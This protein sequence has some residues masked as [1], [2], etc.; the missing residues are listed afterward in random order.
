MTEKLLPK[1]VDEY[2][3]YFRGKDLRIV[4][5]DDGVWE[6]LEGPEYLPVCQG[7]YPIL[8]GKSSE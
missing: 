8:G 6:I 7:F 4:H 1:V 2:D 3:W 5:Y